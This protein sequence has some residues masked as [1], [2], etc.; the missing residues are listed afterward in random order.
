MILSVIYSVFYDY[1][2]VDYCD[3]DKTLQDLKKEIDG[4]D[5]IVFDFLSKRY[6]ITQNIM[7]LKRERGLPISDPAR[8]KEIIKRLASEFDGKLDKIYIKKL[9]KTIF[10]NAKRKYYDKFVADID[11]RDIFALMEKQPIIIAG[12]CAIES[13]EQISILA[14]KIAKMGIRFLR[15]GAFKPRTAPESFQGIGIEGLKNMREAA[16]RNNLLVVSEILDTK[17]LDE[18]YDMI[19]I[20]H[21]GTRNMTSSG[22]LKYVGKK[23]SADK[24][25]VLLKRGYGS[26]L[27]EFIEAAKYITN[28]GNKNVILC[29]R[30]IRTFEQIDS[31]LRF[32]PDLGSILELKEMTGLPVFFDPSHPAGDAKYVAD[33][34][35]AAIMLGAKGIMVE[36]HYDPSCAL[37]D[38]KQS[39]LPEELA[40]LKEEVEFL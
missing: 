9:Y 40:I 8:E 20:I 25:P 24:K 18:C 15:G 37:S 10:A 7:K 29:L 3:M 2:K 28:E 13:E 22:F 5:K 38:G 4:I 35:K 33:I 27:N 14:E 6:G 39:I 34:A 23:T 31:K 1:E 32:T 30:G 19:D 16:D 17:Q 11:A 36:T 12:P 26:T 21:I